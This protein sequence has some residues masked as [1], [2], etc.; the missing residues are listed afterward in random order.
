MVCSEALNLESNRPDFDRIA[1]G[2]L[3]GDGPE[4]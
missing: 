2:P 1:T 3:L 4:Q